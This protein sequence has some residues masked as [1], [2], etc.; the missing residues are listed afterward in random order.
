MLFASL[1]LLAAQQ[2]PPQPTFKTGVNV[3]EVDVVVVDK[4][5][6]PVRGL[7][8]GDFEILEDG[9][10]VEVATFSAVDLPA[11]PAGSP[12]PPAD[13][14]ATSIA[15]NDQPDDGRVILIVLDDYHVAFDAGR[16]GTVRS[17]AR[18]LVE[19]LG[20]SDQ[21]AVMA[22]S[23]R[24][25]N[26]SEFTSDKARLIAAIDRFFPQSEQAAGNIGTPAPGGSGGF[27]F[28]QELKARWAMSS[29]SGAA[30]ALATIP[31]RRKAVLLVSQGL[32][33]SLE[34]IIRDPNANAA[35]EAVREFILT[36]ERSNIAIYTVDPCGLE[37]DG[38]CSTDSRNNLRSI[39]EGTG[40]FAVTFTNAPEIGVDRMVEE[41]G[42]YYLIG[43]YSPAPLY[44]GKRHGIKVRMREGGYQVRARTGYIS[45]RR[46]PSSTEA[47]PLDALIGAPIQTRGLTMRVVAVPAPL[48]ARSGSSV[49]VTIELPSAE[50]A[51]AGAIEFAVVAADRDG[52][53]RGRHRFRSNFEAL[54]TAPTGWTR[55][56]ARV[57][58]PDGRYQIRVAGVVPNGA[59]GSVYTDVA[60]PK[61]TGDLALGGLSLSLAGATTAGRSPAIAE[62]LPLIPIATRDFA[63]GARIV[64]QLP[65]R[66]ASK[67]SGLVAVTATIV[68]ADGTST[69]I[70]NAS[71]PASDY[72]K[73]A[74]SVYRVAL[75]T[76][77]APGSYRLLV[78]ARAGNAR[79]AREV[80]F[81]IVDN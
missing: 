76:D 6:Q 41:S 62:L 43:Y 68:G 35:A 11:A 56:T 1:L 69:P 4:K 12:I 63:P 17:T 74:D 10:P 65:V 16:M 59:R 7:K 14:S 73:G 81:R 29:L 47:P 26:Q 75:P 31:H 2:A 38:G 24:T 28:V 15:A 21:A 9:K 79:G 60:V 71:T 58:V 37:F 27:G 64:A 18:R 19:R 40:G 34:E 44:D 53:V 20:P 49:A 8:Q 39:A 13:Q 77:L 55:V 25:G 22:T 67:G 36:A 46:P 45:P 78:E 54:T 5:G 32:P 51:R 30:K 72:D 57:D 33:A 80:S 3:V 42:T 50:V 66:A 23:G 52:K 48:P 61:F 70:D